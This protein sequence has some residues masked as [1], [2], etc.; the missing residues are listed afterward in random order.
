MDVKLQVLYFD[1][2]IDQIE[3]LKGQNNSLSAKNSQLESEVTEYHSNITN[4][5]QQISNIQN[6]HHPSTYDQLIKSRDGSPQNQSC[7]LKLAL[8]NMEQMM[9]LSRKRRFEI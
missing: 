6:I 8:A 9:N 3:Q 1:S 5:Q 4:L 2:L 7:P